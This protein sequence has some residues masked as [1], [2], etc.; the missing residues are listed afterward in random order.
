[1]FSIPPLIYNRVAFSMIK[2]NHL[3]SVSDYGQK[4]TKCFLCAVGRCYR[5]Y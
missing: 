5:G 3:W 4:K 1:M 2:F